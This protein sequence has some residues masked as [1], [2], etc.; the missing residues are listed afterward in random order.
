MEF[1]FLDFLRT[2]KEVQLKLYDQ[3]DNI[4]V[5]V[6][7]RIMNNGDVTLLN[8]LNQKLPKKLSLEETWIDLV[9]EYYHTS[10]KT[11]YEQVLRRS[12]QIEILR[13]RLVTCFAA[14]LLLKSS[15]EKC[16]PEAREVLVYFG[17]RG[18]ELLVDIERRLMRDN[19]T[20]KL[21]DSKKLVDNKQEEVNFWRLVV[22]LE[23]AL[24]RQID[25]NNMTLSHW[26]EL[27]F[28]VKEKAKNKKHGR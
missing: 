26:I 7:Y 8:P 21:M 12:K 11:G 15:G 1:K 28:A 24:E 2:G 6:F 19:S 22:Q 5:Q 18:D 25:I 17:F 27:I 20:L 14:L 16:G 10:N 13:N 4:P 3:M 23:E 9:E